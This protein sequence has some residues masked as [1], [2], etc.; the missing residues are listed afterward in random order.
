MVDEFFK[1]GPREPEREAHFEPRRVYGVLDWPE[2]MDGLDGEFELSLELID[3]DSID[4]REGYAANQAWWTDEA[5]VSIA[6]LEIDKRD[7]FLFRIAQERG[8]GPAPI[9][10]F[11]IGLAGGDRP[12][13]HHTNLFNDGIERSAG[14]IT[15][16]PPDKAQSLSRAFSL[17]NMP[18]AEPDQIRQ[19]LERTGRESD[20]AML[21][22][23]G[24]GN[25]AALYGRLGCP[26]I[27]IDFGGGVLAN[28]RTYPKHG[29]E[30]CCADTDLVI[31]SHWDWD[32]WSSA[33]RQPQSGILDKTWLAPPDKSIGPV[34]RKFAAQLTNLQI[35]PDGESE[36]S[37]GGIKIFRCTG[38]T[39]NDSGLG[40]LWKPSQSE[41]SGF[42]FPGDCDYSYLPANIKTLFL[43]GIIASH[44][45]AVCK[46]GTLPPKPKS[47]SSRWYVSAG[48][49]NLYGHPT[50][51]GY[52]QHTKAGWKHASR[53]ETTDRSASWV[54][55]KMARFPFH[56]ACGDHVIWPRTSDMPPKNRWCFECDHLPNCHRWI[57]H[58]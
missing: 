27:F 1:H 25:A 23:I 40:V 33:L 55:C 10:E 12:T 6:R 37:G 8:D 45:G 9:V 51:K 43:D 44:H 4:G 49:G 38:K 29:C 36:I 47:S 30:F 31:L 35:W 52:R 16:V 57:L 39:R 21:Y 46:S 56:G 32:H 53:R 22:D 15:P 42:L 54:R 19:M 50:S 14:P 17:S 24:Q 5:R 20:L 41:G 7:D 28:T 13:I 58:E 3:A 11:E 2:E 34:H 26:R 48:P 18:I